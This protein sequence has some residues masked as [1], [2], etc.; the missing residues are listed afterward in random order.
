[1]PKI[2]LLSP[3]KK[4]SYF[5]P[6]VFFLLVLCAIVHKGNTGNT[7][8]GYFYVFCLYKYVKCLLV[9]VIGLV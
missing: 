8:F 6:L 4:C 7:V 2:V 1:M 5:L 3:K 9:F